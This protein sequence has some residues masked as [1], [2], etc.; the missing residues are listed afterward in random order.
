MSGPQQ[1]AR[2]GRWI[3]ALSDS[4]SAAH[5]GAWREHALPS[6]AM[7]VGSL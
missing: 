7:H 1:G 4:G 2:V 6:G 5:G 3:G